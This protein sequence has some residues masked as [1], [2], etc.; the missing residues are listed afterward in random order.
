MFKLDQN[1]N[2]KAK[3]IAKFL[4]KIMQRMLLVTNNNYCACKYSAIFTV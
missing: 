4:N 3:R 1:P 2:I